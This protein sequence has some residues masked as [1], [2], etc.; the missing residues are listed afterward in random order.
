MKNAKMFNFPTRQKEIYLEHGVYAK[1]F[2]QNEV[3]ASEK[4]H[5]KDL[6]KIERTM[7]NWFSRL[8]RWDLIYTE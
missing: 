6:Q 5:T 4:A 8:E 2:N 3:I 7:L 1:K